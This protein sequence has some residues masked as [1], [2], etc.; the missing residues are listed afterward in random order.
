M[1]EYKH[2]PFEAKDVSDDGTFYG[3]GAVFGN[4]DAGGDL[5]LP[6][7]MNKSIKENPKPKMLWQHDPNSV[8]GVWEEVKIDE[9]AMHVKGR[10]L[11][12][13]KKGEEALALMKA[14]ALDG[15]SIGYVTEDSERETRG[16]RSIR[17]LKEITVMEVSVVTFPMNSDAR[18]TDV[19]Q[20]SGPGDVEFL[21]R[22]AGVPGAFAKLVSRFGFEGA[23]KRISGDPLTDNTGVKEEVK[24]LIAKIETLK[25]KINAR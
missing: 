14:G 22:Q 19:K 17:I 6:G 5:I 20:L 9:K 12:E 3:K 21:L 25:E 18:V 4:V 23:M 24:D 8:I 7:A 1:N 11:K 10:I 15:L 16:K 13:V 2:L